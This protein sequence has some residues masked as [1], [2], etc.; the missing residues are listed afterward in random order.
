MVLYAFAFYSHAEYER[1][2]SFGSYWDS[3]VYDSYHHQ[4]TVSHFSTEVTYFDVPRSIWDDLTCSDDTDEYI[5]K[6]I[7]GAFRSRKS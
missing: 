3:L 4:L 7:S 2:D 1:F 5:D 6:Y